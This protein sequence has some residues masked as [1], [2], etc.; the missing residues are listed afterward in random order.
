MRV[1]LPRALLRR[2]PRR[3]LVRVG[4][5]ALALVTSING[6]VRVFGHGDPFWCSPLHLPD[7][8]RALAALARHTWNHDAD[9]GAQAELLVARAAARNGVPERLALSVAR[10]ESSFR[11]HA[12]SRTGAMGL[13]QLMPRTAAALGVEDAFDPVQNA[14][15]GTRYLGWLSR[16]YR[17]DRV[18][19]IAAY[20]AGPARVPVSGSLDLPAET[21]AYV[22]HVLGGAARTARAEL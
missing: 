14:D 6:A 3:L 9:E 18:R 2:L 17:G 4:L 19:A 7:K 16:R 15:A 1:R 11:P 13:M 20:N 12:I 21:R 8:L 10:S 5:V 22:S